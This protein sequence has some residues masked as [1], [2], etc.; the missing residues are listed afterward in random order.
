MTAHRS[1]SGGHRPAAITPTRSAISART[2]ENG[3][4]GGASLAAR[5]LRGHWVV[6][7]SSQGDSVAG[8]R[9]IRPGCSPA[10]PPPRTASTGC[11]VR[12][13][14]GR[15]CGISRT[16]TAFRRCC[17]ISISTSWA[18]ATLLRIL[19]SSL[20][21]HPITSWKG[22]PASPSWCSLPMRAASASS[23]T[24]IS[25]TA[26]V[27][28]MRV[29]GN[30]FWEIFVPDANVGQKYK[31]EIFTRDGRLLIKSDPYA[32]AAE[33][34]PATASIIDR[35]RRR[36]KK[37]SEP[38]PGANRLD[39]PISIY[40]VHLG[41]WRR[42]A[43][44][45]NRWLT[46]RELAELLPAYVA[47]L[48][49]HACGIH[50]GDGASLRRLVGLPADRPLRADEPVRHAGRFPRSRRRA[51]TVAWRRCDPRLGAGPF[52][53]RSAR[54]R[55]FRRHRRLRARQP[56]A[57]PSPGLGHADLQLR[58]SSEV[59]NFLLVQCAVLAR[60]LRRRRVCASMPSRR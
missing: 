52:P 60:S 10:R 34:R 26:A 51:F 21:A 41:S 7:T 28:P 48:G 5:C 24:S 37:A 30:G 14:H 36:L 57:G 40:E 23:A 50:A 13:W 2:M 25:G 4:A 46:Y 53:R 44:E 12:I 22:S 31:Y 58:P 33:M 47:E 43:E 54:A 11:K 55:S 15:N 6:D 20:G 8:G 59:S 39:A 45:D 29:R 32:F 38:P 49:F 35:P 3:S 16:R 1:G 42:K 56:A 27:F 9:S 19:R 17:P 18:K